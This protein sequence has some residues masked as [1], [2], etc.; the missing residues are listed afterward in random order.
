MAALHGVISRGGVFSAKECY[1]IA[2]AMLKEREKGK[3]SIPI[4]EER[5]FKHS[6]RDEMM[7]DINTNK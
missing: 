3:E 7:R 2:D 6:R 1:E 5:V 4:V